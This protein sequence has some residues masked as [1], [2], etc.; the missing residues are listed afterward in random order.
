MFPYDWR[1]DNGLNADRLRDY[2]GCVRRFHPEVDVKVVTHSMGSLLARRY[3]LDQ[4]NDHHVERLITIGAPWLGAPKMLNVLETGAFFTNWMYDSVIKH[5]LGSFDAAHQLLPSRA[6]T[7]SLGAAPP[8]VEDGRDLDGDG[9]DDEVFSHDRVIEVVDAIYGQSFLPGSTG[10]SFHSVA[11]QDDWRFDTTTIET[12]HIY[13]VQS[14]ENTIGQVRAKSHTVCYLGQLLCSTTPYT[15][16]VLTSG[17]G[18][19][20]TISASRLP[21]GGGGGLNDP[22]AKLCR[23]ESADES[24]DKGVEHN[25]LMGN[26]LVYDKVVEYLFAE[27]DAQDTQDCDGVSGGLGP[28]QPPTL[29][30]V[31]VVGAETIVV[32]DESAHELTIFPD[33]I[34]GEVPGVGSFRLGSEISMITLPT[35]PARSFTIGLIAGPGPMAIEVTTGS[36]EEVSDAVRFLDLEL[37]AGRPALLSVSATTVSDLAYDSTGD[38]FPDSTIL[39]T[40]RVTGAEAADTDPPE[41]SVDQD[42]RGSAPGSVAVT[43]EAND[44]VSGPATAYYSLD[45]SQYQEVDGV[46]DIDF[47]QH[48][49]LWVWADDH[50]GNRATRIVSVIDPNLV[51]ANGFETSGLSA[52]D[53]AQP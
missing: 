3:I 35:S 36:R 39:A 51:F 52:W 14:Q 28:T 10:D 8:L 53:L 24:L 6:Y 7:E 13:G 44:L 42:P 20:P 41:I 38:G 16:L 34:V 40:V 46:V 48:A 27:G 19:V 29:H 5:I 49:T 43:I 33:Q 22:D 17:D 2:I 26:P 32:S 25:G 37:V 45:G 11:G 15:K 21:A 30:R 50:V 47:I 4:G 18:T 23:V 9:T 1:R 12:F 31:V